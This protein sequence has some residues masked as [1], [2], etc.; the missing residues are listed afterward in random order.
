MPTEESVEA[1]AVECEIRVDAAPETVFPFFTDPERMTRWMGET[2]TLDPRPGGVCR[3]AV[4]GEHTASGEYVEVDPPRRVV[5]TWGWEHEDTLVK[6][7]TS[8]VE[9]ELIPDQEGTLVRLTHSDLPTQA[10]DQHRAGW[11]HYLDRL[12]VAAPG[13]NPGPDRGPRV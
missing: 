5:F 2:A 4:A 1:G 8:T 12:S 11:T 3:V 6:P 10:R 9:V 7:G 13:G